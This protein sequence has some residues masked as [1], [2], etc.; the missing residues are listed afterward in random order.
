MALV[1]VAQ[2]QTYV[3]ASSWQGGQKYGLTNQGQMLARY[4]SDD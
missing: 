3:R 2:A 4:I 1:G